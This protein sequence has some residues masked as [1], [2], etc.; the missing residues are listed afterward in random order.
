[1]MMMAWQPWL[2]MLWM[3]RYIDDDKF[4]LEATTTAPRTAS[5]SIEK[6]QNENILKNDAFEMISIALVHCLKHPLPLRLPACKVST[7]T[8]TGT[9]H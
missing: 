6:Q 4:K 2:V 9:I 8:M 5:Q 1:M 3:K 7:I